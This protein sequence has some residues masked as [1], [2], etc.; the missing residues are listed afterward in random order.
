VDALH[1]DSRVAAALILTVGLGAATVGLGLLDGPVS[2]QTREL[3]EL[4]ARRVA[5]DTKITRVSG[6][7][8]SLARDVDKQVTARRGAPCGTSAHVRRV[9]RREALGTETRARDGRSAGTRPA[10][11]GADLGGGLE[12]PRRAVW[13]F[14]DL[15]RQHVVFL[16]EALSTFGGR[17][18]DRAFAEMV[19]RTWKAMATR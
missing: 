7:L 6:E 5:Y 2:P 17:E 8:Q 10:T 19:S 12:R 16:R 11:R 4:Q 18:S 15:G 3:A 1:H 14:R 9:H 13:G